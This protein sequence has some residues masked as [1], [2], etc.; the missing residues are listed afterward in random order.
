MDGSGHCPTGAWPGRRAHRARIGPSGAPP[1]QPV[2]SRAD[3]YLNVTTAWTSLSMPALRQAPG[4]LANIGYERTRS[5]IVIKLDS[6]G[7]CEI[8]PNSPPRTA[9][10]RGKQSQVVHSAGPGRSR[11]RPSD[12][13]PLPLV[14][15]E[16]AIR[17]SWTGIPAC[18]T[19]HSRNER[20]IGTR[21][22]CCVTGLGNVCFL[23][24]DAQSPIR[25]L[26]GPRTM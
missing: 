19:L 12:L 13:H 16:P 14:D 25:P 5:D 9:T 26:C 17:G 18:Q 2:R 24:S 20:R 15:D 3:S 21:L 1:W 8:P 4:I 6:P 7:R 10:R 22:E 11:R 23:D